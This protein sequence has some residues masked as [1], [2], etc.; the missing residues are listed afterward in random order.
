MIFFIADLHLNHAN[1]I[2]YC[3][4]P[5]A[6]VGEMNRAL[7]LNW[8]SV[9]GGNDIVFL[10][11]DLAF[12]SS[13]LRWLRILNGNI[14][15]IKGSHDRCGLPLA[16]CGGLLV[17]HNPDHIPSAWRGWVVH[18]H[19]HNNDLLRYPL[20]NPDKRTINVSAEVIGYK[21]ISLEEIARRI[22]LLYSTNNGGKK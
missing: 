21:P 22:M 6:S 3:N 17:V 9:V 8:N 14:I 11:G 16:Y 15:L 1:I 20:I 7:V 5:F 4:R 2:R 13:P 10:V 18:G 19:K 12:G